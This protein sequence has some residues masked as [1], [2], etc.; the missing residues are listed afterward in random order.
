MTLLIDYPEDN[1][2]LNES[3]RLTTNG[4]CSFEQARIRVALPHLFFGC[5]NNEK[6]ELVMRSLGK[7]L[8]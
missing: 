8:K 4:I 6:G 7:L 2:Q 3:S 1:L 5:S